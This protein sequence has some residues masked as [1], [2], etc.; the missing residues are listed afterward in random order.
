MVKTKCGTF[1]FNRFTHTLGGFMA[2]LLK[3]HGGK[4]D[5]RLAQ[6]IDDL[7]NEVRLALRRKG[8]TDLHLM[9]GYERAL[10]SLLAA[11]AEKEEVSIHQLT[12]SFILHWCEGGPKHR[13][14][15]RR[16]FEA[17]M[18]LCTL[19]VEAGVLNQNPMDGQTNPYSRET[20]TGRVPPAR[21]LTAD[22]VARLIAEPKT[23]DPLI[24]RMHLMIC[25]LLATN[26]QKSRGITLDELL[27][28]VEV[29]H[30]LLP[31]RRLRVGERSKVRMYALQGRL[32]CYL[33]CYLTDVRP[34][35]MSKYY[36]QT[37][38][39]LLFPSL[40]KQEAR[41]DFWKR[42]IQY[43]QFCGVPEAN[44]LSFIRT[45]EQGVALQWSECDADGVLAPRPWR[46]S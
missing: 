34:R 33:T 35:L 29:D 4:A 36:G 37:K 41:E 26:T 17:A 10:R 9:A 14:T 44:A 45:L 7:V 32:F 5:R 38:S 3:Q 23:D 31:Q 6:A 18:H 46:V 1:T 40:V 27:W 28:K 20:V 12:S 22:E 30:V 13:T 43:G 19:L 15:K 2:E 39:V 21:P 42:L 8:I 16:R 25:L 11:L 24:L